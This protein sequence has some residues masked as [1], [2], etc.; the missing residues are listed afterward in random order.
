M[1]DP[2][3]EDGLSLAE[4]RAMVRELVRGPVWREVIAPALARHMQTV[5]R[6][7]AVNRHAGID[8]VRYLQGQHRVL[9]S[10]VEDPLALLT[11]E[12]RG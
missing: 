10:L 12:K 9:R 5:E 6:G 1:F 11:S 4:D 8:E 2:P 3:G 7:L